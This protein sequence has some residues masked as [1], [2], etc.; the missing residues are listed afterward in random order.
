[1]IFE[2]LYFIIILPLMKIYGLVY[3]F[4]LPESLGEG[5]RLIVFSLLINFL[6]IPIYAQMELLSR[7]KKLVKESVEKDVKRLKKHFRGRELYYYIRTAYRQNHYNILSTFLGSADL[8]IQILVFA[9]VFRFLS[10]YELL[11]G[12]SFGPIPNLGA[13]DHL[14]W[15]LNLIPIL[16]TALNMLSVLVYIKDR[17]QRYK[18]WVISIFFLVLLYQ[19]PSGLVIY[20]TTNNLFSLIRNIIYSISNKQIFIGSKIQVERINSDGEIFISSFDKYRFWIYTLSVFTIFTLLYVYIP[21]TIFLTS[22]G[23]I[24]LDSE[25][26]F[27][28]RLSI[29]IVFVYAFL[30]I[31]A[32]I[33]IHKIRR[34]LAL[35][36]L[37]V[38]LVVLLY[39]YVMPYGYPRVA[40]MDFEMLSIS[41]KEIIF[42]SFADIFILALSFFGLYWSVNKINARKLITLI[43][44]VNI[45]ISSTVAIGIARND[46]GSRGGETVVTQTK[47]LH[48]SP[49]YSNVL[50]VMLDRFMGGYMEK[51]I[52]EN[53]DLKKRLQ[54]FVWYPLSVASGENSIAGIHPVFGGYDYTPDE[55]NKRQKPLRDLSV[56]AFSIL[57]INF[58]SKQYQVNFVDPHGLGFT[59]LGDCDYLKM[60]NVNCSHIPQTLINEY[61]KENKFHLRDL[62]KSDYADMLVILSTMR[63]AP[64]T[65]KNIIQKYAPWRKVNSSER[66]T[67]EAWSRLKMLGKLSET[68]AK[69]ANLNIII[70]LLT[71]E[72]Y[73]L[74]EDC[75][76]NQNDLIVNMDKVK[77]RGHASLFSLQHENAARCS[78][79]LLADY[80]DKLKSERVYDN[81]TMIIVSDHGLQGGFFNGEVYV[82]GVNDVSSRAMA[83]GT[84]SND[85]VKSRSLLL[86]KRIG[87]KGNLRISDEFKPN[88]ETPSIACEQIGGCF[89]PFL[90]NRPIKAQGRDDPFYVSFVPWQFTAQQLDSFV[91][92]KQMILKNKN[93]YNAENWSY[94]K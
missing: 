92:K 90:N 13:P 23:E 30:L 78:L 51:I 85:Y 64:Y 9:T 28:E 16:M 24:G 14:L 81:T 49:E 65:L 12:V 67:F 1:M 40:G 47:L 20:W 46:V 52:S 82:G 25:Y 58:S 61:A 84:T 27:T 26:I 44:L 15:G 86:V 70:N 79:L 33:T 19:S 56:E 8:F 59:M 5:W 48:F 18:G 50:I 10:S 88:A 83:G 22:P 66:T 74:G 39:A 37:Y 73:F 75:L 38:L 41:Y 93:P 91:I 32:F 89:N 31:Y 6:L 53:P 54:G 2:F 3:E 42:R 76:P 69:K 63:T 35:S 60:P 45:S 29:V 94:K 72:P 36:A 17:K 62:S 55:M 68:K 4:L 7:E 77:Q 21:T 87:E 71:H 43:I 57:P 80:F 11:Q 34:Y